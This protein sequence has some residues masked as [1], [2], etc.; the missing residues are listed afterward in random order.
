MN[1]VKSIA[2]WKTF[3]LGY[4]AAWDHFWFTP[5][6]PHTLGVLRIITGAFLL[7]SHLVLASDLESFLGDNAWIDNHTAIALHDGTFGIPDVARSYLGA[8]SNP[9]L[10]W[11]HHGLTILITAS[12][13]AGFLTRITAPA[14]WFLQIM[15]LHRLTGA[16]F[17]FDQI[18]TYATMY[19]MLAPSGSCFSIDAILR[20]RY[21]DKRLTSRR[22]VWLFPEAVPTVSANIATRL[23]QLH[24][25]VIYLFGGLAKA[26]GESWWDGTA[27]WFSVGNYEYQ[28]V[29]MTW[30]ANFPRLFTAMS[31][32]TLFWEIFYCAIIWP[33]RTRPIALA[34]AVAIHGGIALTMGMMTFGFMMIAANGIFIEPKTVMRWLR[35]EVDQPTTDADIAEGPNKPPATSQTTETPSQRIEREA[36]LSKR[37][38]QVQADQEKLSR[39][40]TR[41]KERERKY[42]ERVE[43]L[44]GREQKIKELIARHR[45]KKNGDESG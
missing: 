24:L 45:A 1:R 9:L 15:Y 13:M 14:A 5:R 28:S 42:R 38:T 20:R 26:R 25:C 31:H 7:Y 30:L 32:I 21:A 29:D 17:G 35:R 33:R 39:R 40:R 6:A 41:L 44:K 12:F 34:M 18:V 3:L 27:I 11:F 16:L 2:S 10:I 36:E 19:L 22:L 43:T 4:A 8:L 37:E 23:L